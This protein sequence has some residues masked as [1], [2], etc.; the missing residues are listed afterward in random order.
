[1]KNFIIGLLISFF[2]FFAP[3]KGIIILVS[4]FV[5]LD[6]IMGIYSSIKTPNGLDWNNFKSHKLFNLAVKTFFYLSTIVLS[7]LVDK[8][9]LGGINLGFNIPFIITKLM[10]FVWIY[11][12]VKSI[13][14]KSQK[15]GNRSIWVILKELVA[16]IKKI[17]T[18]FNSIK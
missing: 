18:D 10:A 17:K 3:I 5:G 13:D 8:F 16:R 14:E 15:L 2:T 6:T 1:M 12:E 7:F 4:L 11:I 9:L